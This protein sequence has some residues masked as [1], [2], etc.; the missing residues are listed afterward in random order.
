MKIKSNGSML[1]YVI[2]IVL[3]VYLLFLRQQGTSGYRNN[4]ATR[5]SYAQGYYD[6]ANGVQTTS[7]FMKV[8]TK[9]GSSSLKR[10]SRDERE[11]YNQGQKDA[12]EYAKL[13]R[14]VADPPKI[15]RDKNRSSSYWQKQSDKKFRE[16]K[17]RMPRVSSTT[18]SSSFMF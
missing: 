14:Y 13:R 4:Q 11:A 17:K 15:G 2:I 5:Q 18:S 8:V 16:I 6:Y 3:V 1:L 9:K 12:I 10:K 7:S